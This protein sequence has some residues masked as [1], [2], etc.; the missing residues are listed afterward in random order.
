MC[1]FSRCISWRDHFFWLRIRCLS[2]KI[3]DAHVQ[4]NGTTK[5]EIRMIIYYCSYCQERFFAMETW[6]CCARSL[7][8]CAKKPE[9][10]MSC[11]KVV[12][13][14]CNLQ[15]K[16]YHITSNHWFSWCHS[17]Q[18][19]EDLR[20]S[21]EVPC[22]VRRCSTHTTHRQKYSHSKVCNRNQKRRP[23]RV[24]QWLFMMFQV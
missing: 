15:E 9:S 18:P 6:L 24:S 8:A 17:S 2:I 13:T 22:E 4:Y 7:R 1:Y 14:I 16:I 20:A 11:Q 10:Y 5:L 23:H 12:K 21:S 19:L 3:P